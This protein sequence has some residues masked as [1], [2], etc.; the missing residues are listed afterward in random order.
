[1]TDS[2]LVSN[3]NYLNDSQALQSYGLFLQKKVFNYENVQQ[4]LSW[5]HV[6]PCLKDDHCQNIEKDRKIVTENMIEI[7]EKRVFF[8]V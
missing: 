7:N 5:C 6:C 8:Y 2:I 3:V 1:M 4:Y